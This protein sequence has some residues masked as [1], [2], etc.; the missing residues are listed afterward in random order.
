MEAPGCEELRLLV[1]L[2]LTGVHRPFVLGRA[3]AAV[4]IT[5]AG[6]SMSWC[7]DL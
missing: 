3:K 6:C 2:V 5:G 4:L 7:S 1:S